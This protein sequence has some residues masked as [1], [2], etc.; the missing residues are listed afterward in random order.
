[1]VQSGSVAAKMRTHGSLF[2]R[3]RQR[4]ILAIVRVQQV[5]PNVVIVARNMNKQIAASEYLDP[6]GKPV[7]RLSF[8]VFADVLGHSNSTRSCKT[9][10]DS[11]AYCRRF[12]EAVDSYREHFDDL[13]SIGASS[14]GWAYVAFSDSLVLGHPIRERSRDGQ[15]ELGSVFAKICMQQAMMASSGFFVRGGIS[16]GELHLS[17]KLVYGKALISAHKLDKHGEPP[18]IVLSEPLE[19]LA[20][21]YLQS[22]SDPG[23]APEASDFLVDGGDGRVFVNYLMATNG[24]Y[25]TAIAPL[26]AHRNAIAERLEE[27]KNSAGIIKKYEW[28]RDY[29]NFFCDNFYIEDNDD[30]ISRTCDQDLYLPPSQK[31]HIFRRLAKI[32]DPFQPS[33]KNKIFF[34]PIDFAALAKLHDQPSSTQ[35]PAAPVP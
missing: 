34:P 30:Y 15:G 23:Q 6:Q 12:H 4:D 21:H 25:S 9:L 10:T 31:P 7:V 13:R 11:E 1:M 35:G 22:Y 26:E 17:S 28:L 2:S 8:C 20:R 32:Q 29:H 16:F 19:K 24:G 5:D 14:P 27:H 33:L 3:L 18:R